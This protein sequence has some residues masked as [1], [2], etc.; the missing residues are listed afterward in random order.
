MTGRILSTEGH[1]RVIFA[2][3]ESE[4]GGEVEEDDV[5]GA[6]VAVGAEGGRW[7]RRVR[8]E[9]YRDFRR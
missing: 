8:A 4:S 5:G 7:S 6:D 9:L 2:A 3:G 1:D